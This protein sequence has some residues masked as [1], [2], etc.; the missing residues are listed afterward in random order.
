MQ[1][2]YCIKDF[3]RCAVKAVDWT[4]YWILQTVNRKSVA[5]TFLKFYCM[6]DSQNKHYQAQSGT[7]R[8]TLH[9]TCAIN[10]LQP[11]CTHVNS[12]TRNLSLD[13][14]FSKRMTIKIPFISP[15]WEVF[16]GRFKIRSSIHRKQNSKTFKEFFATLKNS[17]VRWKNFENKTFIHSSNYTKQFTYTLLC[18]SASYFRVIV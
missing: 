11:S 7:V 2:H 8:C 5:K 17:N 14:I 15:E 10:W 12:S 9:T 18:S 1:I 4:Q 6:S 3:I 13:L 16:L